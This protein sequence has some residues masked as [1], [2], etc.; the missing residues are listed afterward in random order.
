MLR[1]L[2][3]TS[4]IWLIKLELTMLESALTSMAEAAYT[5][6][7]MLL[8]HSML[9]KNWSNEVTQ[10]RKLKNY[11]VATYLL[12]WIKYNSSQKKFNQLTVRNSNNFIP[13]LLE[14][15]VLVLLFFLKQK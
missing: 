13:L 12:S 6:G 5:V 4:I 11:G 7:K 2:L 3:I 14:S 8:R 10:R 1:I 9:P 15:Y